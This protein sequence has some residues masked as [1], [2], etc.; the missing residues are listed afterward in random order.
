[1]SSIQNLHKAKLA[2]PAS[3]KNMLSSGLGFGGRKKIDTHRIL[4]QSA[5]AEEGPGDDISDSRLFETSNH[6]P[7]AE[8]IV[9]VAGRSVLSQNFMN[10]TED[11]VE[12]VLGVTK[13]VVKKPLVY[14][15]FKE[16]VKRIAGQSTAP[17]HEEFM[18][19][20]C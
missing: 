1:M 9:S 4:L 3:T 2:G 10:G 13:E 12:T 7:Y 14:G 11:S 18:Q 17:T 15:E 5:F 20:T 6:D 8:R 16:A 19:E